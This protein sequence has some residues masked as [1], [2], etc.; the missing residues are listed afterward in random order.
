M[1]RVEE[2]GAGQFA[3]ELLEAFGETLREVMD[4]AGDLL[5]TFRP[6]IAGVERSHVREERL[7]CADVAGGFLATDVLLAR[8]EGETQRGFAA[9][10]FGHADERPGIWRLNSSRVAKNAACGPP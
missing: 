3:A 2:A 6:V 1:E 9:R 10:I 7:R 4:A 8:A 5:E